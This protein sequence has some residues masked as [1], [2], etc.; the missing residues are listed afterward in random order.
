M[1]DRFMLNIPRTPATAA[2]LQECFPTQRG[3]Q[4]QAAFSKTAVDL[5]GFGGSEG[6]SANPGTDCFHFAC[7]DLEQALA[8]FP[9]V[10]KRLHFPPGTELFPPRARLGCCVRSHRGDLVGGR[11]KAATPKKGKDKSTGLPRPAADRWGV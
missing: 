10:G 6:S 1:S 4:I 11:Q 5:V 2:W 8:E 9:E 3:E 7:V